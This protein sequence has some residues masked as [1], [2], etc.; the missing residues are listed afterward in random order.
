MSVIF[1]GSELESFKLW[2]TNQ[3]ESIVAS[4]F[5]SDFARM[6]V[7]HA[8]GADSLGIGKSFTGGTEFWFHFTAVQEISTSSTLDLTFFQVLDD[9]NE[10]IPFRIDGLNG[11]YTGQ[12]WNG[13]SFTSMS[14]TFQFI[15]DTV[16]V[17][18]VHVKIHDTTGRFAIYI[19]GV[20]HDEFTGDTNLYASAQI[21]GFRLK[22]AA[23]SPLY[24]ASM[25]FSEVVV[26]DEPTVAWRVATIVPS[27]AGA[28][29]AWTGAYT[30]V[31]EAV[32]DDTDY[33]ESVTAN[34]VETMVATNLSVAASVMDVQTLAVVARTRKGNSGIQQL[35]LAVRTS[36]TDYYS[37]TKVLDPGFIPIE[38]FWAQNPAT[39][40]Q[41]T[42]SEI[43]GLE[44]GVKSIT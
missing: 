18:D 42:P 15:A 44:I 14:N 6:A 26:A 27:A 2:G 24:S 12:Y 1:A 33:L 20:L 41:W 37:T 17:I 19:D 8:G 5:D 7:E 40:A 43:D 25:A 13:S 31:D 4:K 38:A 28:T 16:T 35:Q 10:E 9:A 11:V 32:I 30:D 36:A 22:G 29:S 34:Q 3:R 21:D 39:V 23:N